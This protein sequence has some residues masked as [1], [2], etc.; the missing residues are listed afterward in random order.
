MNYT[1]SQ[2]PFLVKERKT[3][4]LG[5]Q[6]TLIGLLANGVPGDLPGWIPHWAKSNTGEFHRRCKEF[7]HSLEHAWIE[8]FLVREKKCHEKFFGQIFDL[9]PFEETLNL[10]GGET[11]ELWKKMGLEPH[12]LPK[13]TLKGT[14]KFPGWGIK[15]TEL[16]RVDE[17]IGCYRKITP[18]HFLPYRGQYTFGNEVVLIDTRQKESGISAEDYLASIIGSSR[19]SKDLQEVR[20]MEP[21]LWH[22][23]RYYIT[24][25]EWENHLRFPVARAFDL[26]GCNIRLE[27]GLEANIIP[28]LYPYMPRREDGKTRTWVMCEEFNRDG[29]CRLIA[30]SSLHGGLNAYDLVAHDYSDAIEIRPIIVLRDLR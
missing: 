17:S 27:T 11:V 21:E 20:L 3:I 16:M 18:N 23:K 19:D 7:L 6:R 28:Q 22:K 10:Y 15:P 14:E 13:M 4:D 25:E 24:S 30:G 1:P 8:P 5:E 9:T 26:N 12:Y 2:T 29:S